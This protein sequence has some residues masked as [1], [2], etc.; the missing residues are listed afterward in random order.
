M[1]KDKLPEWLKGQAAQFELTP[2]QGSFD[3]LMRKRELQRK[4]R[5]L[6]VWL[7]MTAV[8]VTVIGAGIWFA[9]TKPEPAT[10][11]E[12]LSVSVSA[13]PEDYSKAEHSVTRETR[14]GKKRSPETALHTN[15]MHSSTAGV[16]QVFTND[17]TSPKI[18]SATKEQATRPASTAPIVLPGVNATPAHP[19]V[20]IATAPKTVENTIQSNEVSVPSTSASYPDSTAIRVLVPDSIPVTAALDSMLQQVADPAMETLT[21]KPAG[22]H[23]YWSI[24]GLFTP[25]IISG[26]YN[27]NS[28]ASLSWMRKYIENREQNDNAQ[29]SFNAGL[30]AERSIGKHW[31]VSMGILYSM[32]KFEEI[33]LLK[34]VPDDSAVQTLGLGIMENKKQAVAAN[35]NRLDI[36]FSSLE[37][38]LQ[39]G[40]RLNHKKMY[41]QLTAGMSYTYLFQTRSLIFDEKDSLLNVEETNDAGNGR[42]NQHSWMLLGGINIGYEFSK[43]WSCYAGPVYRYSLNAIYKEDYFIGPRPYYLGLELGVKYSFR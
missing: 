24:T 27:T 38:P 41:Y 25:Q 11:G 1:E 42:L 37:I 2:Q 4:Q 18:I 12:H 17:N 9:S 36:S 35:Q 15:T 23:S 21:L 33:K 3:V 20:T 7:S 26:V 10:L 13:K 34:E 5:R 30:K 31:S 40:Y 28:F 16:S 22:K 39:V 19:P 43:R 29:Y 6:Y 8:V 32:V 14:P